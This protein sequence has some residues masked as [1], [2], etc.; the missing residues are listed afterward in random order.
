MPD[1]AKFIIDTNVL[2]EAYQRYYSFD[3]AP[4]FWDSILKEIKNGNIIIID[5]VA[6]EIEKG[7]DKL[8]NWV[9]GK[10]KNYI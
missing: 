9:C 10:C 5:R 6:N 3:I 2:I 1:N 7:D 8:K 4:I